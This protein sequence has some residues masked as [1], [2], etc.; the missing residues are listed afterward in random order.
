MVFFWGI[1]SFIISLTLYI[2]SIAKIFSF[3]VFLNT[4]TDFYTPRIFPKKVVAFFIIAFEISL[5]LLL[6]LNFMTKLSFILTALLFT[7]FNIYFLYFWFRKKE[8]SCSCFG[9]SSKNTN[10]RFALIRNSLLIAL[11]LLNI[12]NNTESLMLM[13]IFFIEIII[14]LS[15]VAFTYFKLILRT[16]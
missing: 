11:C 10:I 4:L 13:E 9:I 2:S 16:R 6:S 5:A 12:E 1:S 7:I 14:A 3:D 15:Y 8:V